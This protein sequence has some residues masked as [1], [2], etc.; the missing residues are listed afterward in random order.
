MDAIFGEVDAVEA[1]EQAGGLEKAEVLAV[2]SAEHRE[3]T[4]EKRLPRATVGPEKTV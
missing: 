4:G 2:S 1:G 3:D